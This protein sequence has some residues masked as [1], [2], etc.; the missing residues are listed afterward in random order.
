[1]KKIYIGTIGSILAAFSDMLLLYHPDLINKYENYQFIF[2]ISENRNTIG[3]VLGLVCIP[4]MY[5]GYKGVK[6]ISD[7]YS[8]TSLDKNDWV[9]VFL[10]A[11]GLVVHSVYRFIPAFHL[12]TK[13]IVPIEIS[14]VKLVEVLFVSF[15]FM[16]CMIVTLQSLKVKNTLL[17]ANRF[18]NP[19]FWMVFVVL[20]MII[21]QKIGGYFAVSSFNMSITFYFVG[22][23]INRKKV[24]TI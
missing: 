7:E 14:T 12:Q 4:L 17:Y 18:F 19:L 16:Y 8:K 3:W 1:M 21:N 11:F 23:L 15:Y 22:I 5:I 9:V 10:I 20:I 13:T 2:E 6:E 24:T